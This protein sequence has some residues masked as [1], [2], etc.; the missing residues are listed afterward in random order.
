MSFESP[1]EKDLLTIFPTKV[2]DYWLAQ[3]PI[4]VYGPRKYAFVTLADE[5]GYAKIVT[6]RGP[7]NIVNAIREICSSPGRRKSLV[8]A[9]RKM[10]LVHDSTKIADKLK[11]DLGIATRE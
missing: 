3:R 7:E 6:D 4:I 2:I 5:S 9:S 10:V 11:A 8:A 1:F